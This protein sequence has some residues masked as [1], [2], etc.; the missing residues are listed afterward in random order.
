[1]RDICTKELVDARRYKDKYVVKVSPF[2]AILEPDY[3]LQMIEKAEL[4]RDREIE[5]LEAGIIEDDGPK[6]VKIENEWDQL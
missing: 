6:E 3:Y 2:R 5:R 4:N 1:M